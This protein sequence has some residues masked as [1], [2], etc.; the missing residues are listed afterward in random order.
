MDRACGYFG[1]ND[2]EVQAFTVSD[3]ITVRPPARPVDMAA[4]GD[5]RNGGYP[6]GVIVIGGQS[7]NGAHMVT[8]IDPS[9]VTMEP[10]G[11]SPAE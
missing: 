7:P 3:G 4:T 10:F 8:F 5:A 2:E 9:Q 11:Y 1:S 6:G